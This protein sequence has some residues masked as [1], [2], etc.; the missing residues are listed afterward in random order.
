MITY[1]NMFD[2]YDYIH[3]IGAQNHDIIMS[4]RGA[5]LDSVAR[6]SG[7]VAVDHDLIS[8]LIRHSAW[9][10]TRFRVRASDHTADE[11][12]RQHKYVGA[13][14]EFGEIV[15]ARIPPRRS[16]ESWTSV[17]LGSCGPER[18]KAATNTFVWTIVERGDS[19]P[20]VACQKAA[21]GGAK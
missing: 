2:I 21:G 10:I 8:W 12:F 16:S 1:T 17:G 9:L 3:C 4:A 14:V 19:E 6:I 7:T 13:I 11:L 18:Q 5:H 15:L 20:C